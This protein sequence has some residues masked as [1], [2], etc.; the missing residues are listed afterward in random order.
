MFKI[1]NFCT[2]NSIPNIEIEHFYI[3]VVIVFMKVKHSW[4]SPY[5][6]IKTLLKDKVARAKCGEYH[7]MDLIS[8]K[9]GSRLPELEN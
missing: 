3:L 2:L 7:P 1:L 5:F 6:H 4:Y 8:T 9:T